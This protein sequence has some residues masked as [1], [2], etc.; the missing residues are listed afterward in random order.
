MKLNSCYKFSN[1]P[2]WAMTSFGRN[3]QTHHLLTLAPQ[4][5][6]RCPSLSPTISRT[7]LSFLFDWG[8]L[9]WRA[10]IALTYAHLLLPWWLQTLHWA[11][12]F[13]A[14]LYFTFPVRQILGSWE[15]RIT[16]TGGWFSETNM[17]RHVFKASFPP[18]GHRRLVATYVFYAY[19]KY[20]VPTLCQF[21]SQT[22][23][24]SPA[25]YTVWQKRGL[26]L[27]TSIL[28][29]PKYMAE[30]SL[31]PRIAQVTTAPMSVVVSCT[32]S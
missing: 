15:N 8:R 10:N 24:D 21:M 27:M 26:R 29:C 20:W 28:M 7:F 30:V 12:S 13:S 16:K 22:H 2:F 19:T 11:K 23:W 9:E 3:M 32:N 18:P 31:A 25:Y 5:I 1:C 4:C 14:I 6:Y 17:Q